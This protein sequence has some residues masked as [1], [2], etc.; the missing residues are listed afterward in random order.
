MKNAYTI[1]SIARQLGKVA[2]KIDSLAM[3]VQDTEQG[4]SDVSEVYQGLLLVEVE[5]AVIPYRI[6][7]GAAYADGAVAA[8]LVH[9][10]AGP[11][12]E[13]TYND[14][15]P[16]LRRHRGKRKKQDYQ[17]RQYVS[18]RYSQLSD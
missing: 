3:G 7:L 4:A 12:R 11:C 1:S 14:G 10:R 15:I 17:C 13:Q 18:D 6:H 16:F 8:Q 9:L 5:H 2:E